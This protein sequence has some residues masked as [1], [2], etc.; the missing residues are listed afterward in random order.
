MI[1]LTE[2]ELFSSDESLELAVAELR[3]RGARIAV[4]DAGAGY[5]GL[6]QLVR[7]KPEILKLDRSLV[8]D[9]QSD[10]AKIALLEALATFATTTG[11]AVCAEGIEHPDE[12]LTLSRLDV[13]YAQGYALARP[14]PA[15]PGVAADVAAMAAADARG[16]MRVTPE[17]PVG[18]SAPVTLGQVSGSLANVRTKA[19]LDDSV[20]L[21][22]RLIHSDDVAVSQVLPGERIL[23]ALTEHDWEGADLRYQLDDYPTT[24]YVLTHG[25]IGQLVAGDPAADPAE[26]ALLADAGFAAMLIA[27]IV[28]RCESVGLLE[29]YRREPRPWTPGEVDSARVFAH[30]LGPVLRT[31]LDSAELV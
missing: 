21:M 12:L 13:T 18:E 7:I 22:E 28:H 26:V 9:L 25:E 5:A 6:Q 20:V 14:A 29:I 15:W 10:P 24:E 17:R 11:A 16:G 31:G 19:D 30:Q 3:A 23:E 2:N 1:E 4:D 27:P 8:R